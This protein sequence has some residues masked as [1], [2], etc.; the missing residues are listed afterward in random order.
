M[1][2]GSPAGDRASGQPQDPLPVALRLLRE[3]AEAA[4]SWWSRPLYPRARKRAQRQLCRAVGDLRAVSAALATADHRAELREF[5]RR[6]DQAWRCADVLLTIGNGEPDDVRSE[7]GDV[8][9]AAARHVIGVQQQA[10]VPRMPDAGLAD[11]LATVR[12]MA[13][14]TGELAGSGDESSA[15]QLR[16]VRGH[17]TAATG[18][19]H[20]VPASHPELPE[21][22]KR[23][24]M[25]R[26]T[27]P[28]RGGNTE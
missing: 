17:L 23:L 27:R 21:A 20:A 15:R 22:G 14:V 26:V 19:L 9:R 4:A 3:A 6:L 8:V 18:H 16:R 25:L 5:S 7:H 24:P 1:V 10:P 2:T 12:A 13:D 28:Y 11:L